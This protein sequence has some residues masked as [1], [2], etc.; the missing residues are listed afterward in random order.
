MFGFP[1]Y[2]GHYNW[3][4]DISV[5][6]LLRPYADHEFTLEGDNIPK[7]LIKFTKNKC[8]FIKAGGLVQDGLLTQKIIS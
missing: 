3:I 1:I 2:F 8:V 5:S 7:Q 4:F 6:T